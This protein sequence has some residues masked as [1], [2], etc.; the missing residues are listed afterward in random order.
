MPC[1]HICRGWGRRMSMMSGYGGL[2]LLFSL[3]FLDVLHTGESPDDR[4]SKRH[5]SSQKEEKEKGR[6]PCACLIPSLLSLKP[7]LFSWPWRVR[8]VGLHFIS[9]PGPR[10]NSFEPLS[11]GFVSK[12][13]PPPALKSSF[14]IHDVVKQHG[15]ESTHSRTTRRSQLF[16]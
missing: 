14:R 15:K 10:E 9:A 11:L 16:K 1:W 13:S 12:P 6:K 4:L 8:M 5:L 2:S 3:S 7:L